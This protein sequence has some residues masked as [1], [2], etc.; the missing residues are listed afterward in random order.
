MKGQ[1]L[2]A[3]LTHGQVSDQ[4]FGKKLA[5]TPAEAQPFDWLPAAGRLYL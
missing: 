1:C 3:C 5:V 4:C 2:G